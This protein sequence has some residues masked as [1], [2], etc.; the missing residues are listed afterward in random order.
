MLIKKIT[1]DKS[2]HFEL[3]QPGTA[4]L[5]LVNLQQQPAP[6]N[7]GDTL[8]YY[9]TLENSCLI[10]AFIALSFRCKIQVSQGS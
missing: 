8:F 1:R 6:A 9:D 3:E 10:E 2:E 5:M 4:L 7:C